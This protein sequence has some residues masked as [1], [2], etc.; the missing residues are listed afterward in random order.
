MLLE[1][2]YM[3]LVD[4]PTH[5]RSHHTNTQYAMEKLNK[6]TAVS[7]TDLELKR[8]FVL[9]GGVGNPEFYPADF[10][11]KSEETVLFTRV[12]L[13][14]KPIASIVM[15]PSWNTEDRIKMVRTARELGLTWRL[16]INEWGAAELL[17][18]AMPDTTLGDLLAARSLEHRFPV[19][20]GRLLSPDQA[21]LTVRSFMSGF[22]MSSHHPKLR[23]TETVS[24][25]LLGYPLRIQV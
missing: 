4:L 11:N 18:T 1:S 17:I 13:G 25:L 19:F 6:N 8:N 14:L 10:D 9:C 7:G 23:V 2:W 3:T 24:G 5:N 15:Q 20:Q 12:S 16:I 22:D 21:R